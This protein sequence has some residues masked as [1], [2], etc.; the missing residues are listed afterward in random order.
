MSFKPFYKTNTYSLPRFYDISGSSFTFTLNI[1]HDRFRSQSYMPSWLSS[2]YDYKR[3]FLLYVIYPNRY[4]Q[5]LSYC[6]QGM[7]NRIICCY[8]RLFHHFI[9]IFRLFIYLISLCI[10]ICVANFTDKNSI[11]IYVMIS[12]F[13]FKLHWWQIFSCLWKACYLEC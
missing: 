12:F 5:L 1:C 2:F 9:H 4:N 10:H 6:T 11:C 7:T 8:R 13:A 3:L